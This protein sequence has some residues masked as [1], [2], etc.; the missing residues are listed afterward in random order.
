MRINIK[1]DL[2]IVIVFFVFTGCKSAHS[3]YSSIKTISP[4]QYGLNKAKTGEERYDV[5]YRTHMEAQ[6][7]GVGVSYAGIKKIELKIP[8]KAK[9]IPLAHYTDFAGVTI[10]VDNNKKN[11]YLFSLSSE[12]K[13]V[14]ITGNEID[15]RNFSRNSV[16]KSGSKLLVVTDATPWVENRKGHDYG[17]TRKDIML[18]KNGKSVCNPV[19]SYCTPT[20]SPKGS[21]RDVN[22]SMNIVIK[23]IKFNRTN[24]STKITNLFKVE[25]QCNV[26]LSNITISTP[27]GSGL[28]G[29]MAINIINCYKVSMS[30]VSIIGTYSQDKDAEYGKKYGY[31]ITL[32]NTYD[33]HANKLYARANW[34]V[35]GNNNVNKAHLTNCD[36]NRF[37]IHCYGKD[38]MFENCNFVDLYN[39]F[40]S[41]YGLIS[42]KNCFFSNFTPII[43][44]SSYNAYSAFDIY[45]EK[46]KF[47]F[48]KDHL[49]IISFSG[50]AKEENSRPELKEKCLPNVTLRDCSINA[51]KEIKKCYV[52]DTKNAK[53]YKGLFSYISKVV[54]NDLSINNKAL[55]LVAFSNK[56]K[57]LR[58]VQVEI[59]LKN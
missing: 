57:T 34:G 13:P 40:S 9:S 27:D 28:Y 7:L 33:F 37:D 42:F 23:N 38:I 59:K 41:V 8:K 31:G 20:S 30:D 26:E 14:S 19:Q 56:V 50:F 32:N 52:F 46:C 29:D 5:L 55:E 45:F 43:I 48:D 25:N 11:I 24:T 49:S 39:Q 2:I 53:E 21:Y 35:F 10:Q 3:Y 47:F 15:S 36:I 6:R 44:G 58:E 4:L 54:I 51:S 1:L 12:L 17:A 18:L 16:L 22:E